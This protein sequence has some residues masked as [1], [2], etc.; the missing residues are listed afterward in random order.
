MLRAFTRTQALRGPGRSDVELSMSKWWTKKRPAEGQ[1]RTARW[2]GVRPAL[3][4]EYLSLCWYL[5]SHGV[6]VVFLVALDHS[7]HLSAR[8]APRWSLASNLPKEDH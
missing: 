6:N 3:L 5:L 8:T 4:A 7:Y 1:V 2:K